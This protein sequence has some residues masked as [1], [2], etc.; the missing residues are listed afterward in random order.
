MEQDLYNQGPCG[1][2]DIH[3]HCLPGLDDGPEDMPQA[4][5]LCR[6]LIADGIVTVVAT[7]HM[8]S[9]VSDITDVKHIYT[10]ADALR[11][12]LQ[13]EGLELTV[14]VGAEVTLSDQI[15][16]WLDKNQLP[17]LN[18]GPYLLLELPSSMV[19][20]I[21]PV[22]EQFKERGMDCILAHPERLGYLQNT[23]GM[24]RKWT[25]LGACLQISAAS[26]VTGSRWFSRTRSLAWKLVQEGYATVVASDAHDADVRGPMIRKAFHALVKRLGLAQA[27]QL[28][29]E[30]PKRLLEGDSP[31]PL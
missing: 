7:P 4:L 22:L 23:P 20:D 1:F 25:Q 30:N 11:N 5:Q 24:L 19:M 12:A 18:N 2:V 17:T 29:V 8:L 9:P 16:K 6:A 3:C 21:S 13:D 28:C 14:L 26:L 31:V 27:V 10:M 15:F